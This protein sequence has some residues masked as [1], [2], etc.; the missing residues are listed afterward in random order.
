MKRVLFTATAILGLA[1]APAFAEDCT[2][3]TV[4]TKAMEV[5]TKIQALAATD[6]AKMADL[7][8]KM[9]EA[10][11]RFQDGSNLGEACAYYDEMLAELDS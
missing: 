9:Q 8:P 4:Q 5:S 10:A 1:A 11:T 2:A 3:E 7:M 6:P